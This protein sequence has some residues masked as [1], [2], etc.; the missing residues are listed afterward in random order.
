MLSIMKVG[1]DYIAKGSVDRDAI[2]LRRYAA[3]MSTL[4][5]FS[6]SYWLKLQVNE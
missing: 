5:Y 2:Y 6:D 3:Y 1:G 4:D